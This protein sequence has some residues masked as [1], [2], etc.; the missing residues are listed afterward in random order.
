[1]A[2]GAIASDRQGRASV[3]VKNG[4]ILHIGS[5]PDDDELLIAAHHRRKPY[6][7][8]GSDIDPADD[9]GTGGDP[10]AALLRKLRR[11]AFKLMNGHG[12]PC[13]ILQL[14]NQ[15]RYAHGAGLDMM[16]CDSPSAHPFMTHY[17]SHYQRRRFRQR[18]LGLLVFFCLAAF[19]IFS[20]SIM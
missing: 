15:T 3:G 8:I 14:L 9:R 10:V 17:H 4:A 5:F 20:G 2:D 19:M 16:A 13:E 1:M 6:T 7:R 12:G 11:N 18:S